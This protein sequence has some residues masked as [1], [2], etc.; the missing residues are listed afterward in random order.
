MKGVQT[1]CQQGELIYAVHM[2]TCVNI[3]DTSYLWMWNLASGNRVH[4]LPTR[5]ELHASMFI[6]RLSTVLSHA[7]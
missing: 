6:R 4:N 7:C 5:E 2:L 1:G 3:M